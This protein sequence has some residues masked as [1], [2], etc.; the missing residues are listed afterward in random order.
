MLAL[1]GRA[2]ER[3]NT[4]N[5]MNFPTPRIPVQ[6]PQQLPI[7]FRAVIYRKDAVHGKEEGCGIHLTR[8]WCSGTIVCRPRTFTPLYGSK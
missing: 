6:L 7:E 1:N 4:E 2:G 8:K 3:S 5:S